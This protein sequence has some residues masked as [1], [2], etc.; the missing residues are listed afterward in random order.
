MGW[1]ALTLVNCRMGRT[2]RVRKSIRVK[3]G[4]SHVESQT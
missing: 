1:V 4:L 2:R 3:Y